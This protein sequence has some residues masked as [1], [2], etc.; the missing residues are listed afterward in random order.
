FE[1]P[2]LESKT[3]KLSDFRGK[4]VL[5]IF[6]NPQCGFCVQMAEELAALD[7]DGKDGHP[8]PLVVSAGDAGL[9]RELVQEHKI[10]CPVLLQ[11]AT[12]VASQYQASGTPTGYLIDEEGKLASGLT[13]G[14]Q[15]LLALVQA[16]GAGS[17]EDN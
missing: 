8:V 12:E 1:L 4:R 9:N 7:P 3:R 16:S 11:K 6:F 15:A 13:I 10:A 17:H 5:L 2:D 14:A